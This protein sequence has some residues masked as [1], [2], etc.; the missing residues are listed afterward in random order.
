MLDP[1]NLWIV[2]LP[3]LR[4]CHPDVVGFLVLDVPGCCLKV[5]CVYVLILAD[6]VIC[7]LAGRHHFLWWRWQGVREEG[8]GGRCVCV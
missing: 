6:V 2:E 1:N 5:R 8:V 4:R 3:R 7:H